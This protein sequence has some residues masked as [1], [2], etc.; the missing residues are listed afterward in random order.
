LIANWKTLEGEH[1]HGKENLRRAEFPKMKWRKI[2]V[3]QSR[4]K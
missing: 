3:Y 2:Y 1:E 4:K